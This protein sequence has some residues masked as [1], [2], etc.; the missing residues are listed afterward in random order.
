[1]STRTSAVLGPVLGAIL[2]AGSVL[3]AGCDAA[4]SATTVVAAHAAVAVH[5]S[6]QVDL[7]KEAAG[8]PC[9]WPTL[10]RATY[11]H[12]VWIW[13]ENRSYE[14]MIGGPGSVQRRLAPYFNQLADECG[15]ATDYHNI[16]HPSQP[17]YVA[18]VAGTTGAV[19]TNC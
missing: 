19:T 14:T 2:L 8:P 3:V 4:P 18:A 6:A 7:S 16:S 13:L 17:N 11:D 12:V 5:G 9:G 10:P 15:L 1:M